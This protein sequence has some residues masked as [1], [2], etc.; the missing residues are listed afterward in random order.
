MADGMGAGQRLVEM[1][2]RVDEPRQHDMARGVEGRVKALRRLAAPDKRGDPRPFDDEPPLGAVG[3]DRQRVFDPCP[4]RAAPP[5][6]P[7]PQ[8]GIG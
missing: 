4:H 2:V 3:E 1:V 8:L 7:I 6:Q 5:S